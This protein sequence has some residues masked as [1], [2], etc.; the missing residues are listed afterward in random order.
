MRK[1]TACYINPKIEINKKAKLT[2]MWRSINLFSYRSPELFETT[3]S[4]GTSPETV[5]LQ[6]NKKKQNQL[7]LDRYKD[8]SICK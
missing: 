7:K 2:E 5:Q 3:G 8:A 1:E 4:S 6:N